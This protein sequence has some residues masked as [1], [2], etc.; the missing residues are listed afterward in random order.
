MP[1][2]ETPFNT[3]PSLAGYLTG[4]WSSEGRDGWAERRSALASALGALGDRLVW[5]A[6]R[7]FA[8]L[9]ALAASFAGPWAAAILIA[10]YNP[11]ELALRWRCLRAGSRGPE[12]ILR[13]LGAGGLPRLVVPLARMNAV[14]IGW[15]AGFWFAGFVG[16]GEALPWILAPGMI[17]AVLLQRK[18]RYD[19]WRAVAFAMAIAV[20][21]IAIGSI[22]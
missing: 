13:D 5:G 16:E 20:V 14:L 9:L 19:A 10:V 22:R 11:A 6:L 21:W 3:Q 18:A 17:A 1:D 2:P 7:L 15:L 8:V 12:A 4:W